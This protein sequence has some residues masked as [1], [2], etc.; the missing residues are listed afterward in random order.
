VTAA[1]I[2]DYLTSFFPVLS[3]PGEI[4]GGHSMAS[5][6][7]SVSQ[8]SLATGS[9]NGDLGSGGAYRPQP[10]QYARQCSQDNPSGLQVSKC[11]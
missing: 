4:P 1:K 7:P 2:D 10:P 11:E 6:S 8:S 3:P 5:K 9:L